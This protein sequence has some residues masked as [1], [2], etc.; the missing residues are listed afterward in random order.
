MCTLLLRCGQRRMAAAG[1]ISA[2][3]RAAVVPRRHSPLNEHE[4]TPTY[5]P[6]LF[7]NYNA[8]AV[9]P[10]TSVL[11]P[12]QRLKRYFGLE[13]VLQKRRLSTCSTTAYAVPTAS[14]TSKPR[15]IDT[16]TVHTVT[17]TAVIDI[18]IPKKSYTLEE[19]S[20]A[21]QWVENDAFS[22]CTCRQ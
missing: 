5:L 6:F 10:T 21:Q 12:S 16:G 9:F 20:K 11:P 7:Q 22:S 8:A 15:P 2:A 1:C 3:S 18:D 17:N 14:G 13:R 19:T 4:H